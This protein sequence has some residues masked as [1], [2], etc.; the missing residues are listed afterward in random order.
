MKRKYRKKTIYKNKLDIKNIMGKRG[1]KSK[2]D[3]DK[4][5]KI[6][7]ENP[8]VTAVELGEI[9]GVSRQT[10]YKHLG[11]GILKKKKFEG[12]PYNI[13]IRREKKECLKE[14]MRKAGEKNFRHYLSKLIDIKL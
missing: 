14:Q 5:I 1:P 10:I 6:V 4:L 13:Y 3:R 11:K 8:M 7:Q 9:L 2:I 12:E